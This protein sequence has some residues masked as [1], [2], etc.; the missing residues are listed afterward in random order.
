MTAQVFD[1]LGTWHV[2]P[3]KESYIID[4]KFLVMIGNKLLMLET[5]LGKMKTF[6]SRMIKPVQ[7]LLYSSRDARPFDPHDVKTV[8]DFCTTNNI[9]RIRHAQA[10]LIRAAAL[11]QKDP[12]QPVGLY[13]TLDIA[14][15]EI[16]AT[17]DSAAAAKAEE[18]GKQA[19]LDLGTDVLVQPI[20]PVS[21]YLASDMQDNP[22]SLGNIITNLKLSYYE[23]KPI[24]NPAKGPFQ[25]W[26]LVGLLC[27]LAIGAFAALYLF[28][29]PDA[30]GG[31]TVEE[32]EQLAAT[33]LQPESFGFTTSPAGNVTER[34]PTDTSVFD[35][36]AETTDDVL[37]GGGD[38]P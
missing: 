24:A 34:A 33:S 1:E 28:A 7:T 17:G 15:Q 6:R 22:Q 29:G 21:Q 19:I 4:G 23:W 14:L 37:T 32:I 2:F 11:L 12:T 27:A 25:H 9:T 30:G 35:F 36:V 16:R 31:L 13:E 20:E 5:D 10:L 8:K 38:A 26:L 18:E 3:L